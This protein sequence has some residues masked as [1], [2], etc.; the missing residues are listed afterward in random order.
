M[1]RRE[2]LLLGSIGLLTGVGIVRTG[3]LDWLGSSDEGIEITKELFN[4]NNYITPR[5]KHIGYTNFYEL[6]TNKRAVARLSELLDIEDWT[7]E[8]DDKTFD[9]DQLR[10]KPFSQIDE[11]VHNYRCVE[12]HSKRVVYNSIPLREL[13]ERYGDSSKKYVQFQSVDDETLPGVGRAFGSIEFPYLEYRTM[14]EAMHPLTKA[15]FGEYGREDSPATGMPLKIVSPWMYGYANPKAVVKITCTDEQPRSTWGELSPR[16]Y[17][18]DR[19]VVNPQQSHPRWSQANE[20]FI[21]EGGT[22]RV[23]TELFNGYPEVATLYQA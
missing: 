2:T 6:S 18:F 22:E 9:I 1:N 23:R 4:K 13:I 8:V 5:E 17:G 19:R 14:E 15:V 11:E 10:G 12:G 20:R 21:Y 16:E 7:V 3:V